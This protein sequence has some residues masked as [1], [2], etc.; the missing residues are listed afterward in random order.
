NDAPEVAA[1][2]TA[3]ATEDDAGFSLNLLDGA[4]DVDASDTL[5][6]DNL[7]VTGDTSGV[8][9]TGTTV[10][11]DPSAYNA[12]AVGETAVITYAYDVIDGNG[13]SIAQTATITITGANDA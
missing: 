9:L 10:T 2:L 6:I 11:V 5:A 8:T 1:A 7:V 12:L 13:G 3:T 4:T